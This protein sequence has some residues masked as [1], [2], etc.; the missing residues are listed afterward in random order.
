M[1]DQLPAIVQPGALAALSDDTY[2]VP[3]L[4][5][6]LGSRPPGATSNFHRQP[7]ERILLRLGENWRLGDRWLE[8]GGTIRLAPAL[9]EALVGL[10]ALD[11]VGEVP[12]IVPVHIEPPV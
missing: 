4:I 12:L 5:A 10:I 3:A 11:Y 1:S 9:Y 8:T 2:I 7:R 6:E